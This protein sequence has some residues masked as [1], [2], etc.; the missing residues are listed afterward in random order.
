MIPTPSAAAR[1][2]I[3]VGCV[4]PG[5]G[6]DCHTGPRARPDDSELILRGPRHCKLVRGII[7]EQL[8]VIL[9]VNP[10]RTS[11]DNRPRIELRPRP[12]ATMRYREHPNRDVGRVGGVYRGACRKTYSVGLGADKVGARQHAVSTRSE[13]SEGPQ[14]VEL[15]LPVG[16]SRHP[17][18]P[19]A[20]G[21][22]T[23]EHPIPGNALSRCGPAVGQ[24]G[25]CDGCRRL[26]GTASG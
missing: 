1:C 23:P 20:A 24:L 3:D 12:G 14:T 15:E 18:P 19:T 2:D 26:W 25:H 8:G 5:G 21:P 9:L 22:R 13:S 16:A 17:S 11:K 4:V 7:P 6:R 10:A